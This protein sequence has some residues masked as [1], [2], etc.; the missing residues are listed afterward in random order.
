MKTLAFTAAA[1][2]AVADPASATDLAARR[3]LLL[4]LTPVV[5]AGFAQGGV[6][7]G[8]SG[9]AGFGDAGFAVTGPAP[10]GDDGVAT[11]PEAPAAGAR[12]GFSRPVATWL[13]GVPVM[14]GVEFTGDWAGLRETVAATPVV[15]RG[16]PAPTLDDLETVTARFGFALHHWLLYAKAGGAG[17]ALNL[18]S[19]G[20]SVDR[21]SR[22]IGTTFAG[23]IEYGLAANLAVGVEYDFV[24][25][26]PGTFAGAAATGTVVTADSSSF[27]VHT[28][29]GRLSYRF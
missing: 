7:A 20:A 4:P 3:Q 23:G 29:A 17:G 22:A 15:A 19:T 6:Y 18:H 9:G 12:A 2:V 1:V 13:L 10:P 27:D 24:R 14:L 28:I 25:L 8:A 11:G 5:P 26:F 16:H 21:T